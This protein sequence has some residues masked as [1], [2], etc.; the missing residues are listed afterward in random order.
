MKLEDVEK[1]CVGRET[2]H[3][4]KLC[5]ILDPKFMSR[6]IWERSWFDDTVYFPFEMLNLPAPSG[7]DGILR[8]YYGN[9]HEFVIRRTPQG[10]IDPEATFYDIER[11]YT[12]YTQEG[13]MP[14]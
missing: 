10:I 3:V 2:S 6:R 12:Y 8:A 4:S 11:P 9:W 14:E 5:M 1:S 13:H 7:W